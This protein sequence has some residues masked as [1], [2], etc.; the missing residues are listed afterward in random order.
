MSDIQAREY[1][2]ENEKLKNENIDLQSEIYGLRLTTKYLDKELAG[3]IQQIQLLNRDTRD[4]TYENLWN[5]L[6]SEI[7]LNRHKTVIRAC[8][9]KE[10]LNKDLAIPPG[11]VT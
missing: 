7:H 9:G 6:E 1:E 10:I 8:R 11:H 4:S 5:Q 3:R 2:K